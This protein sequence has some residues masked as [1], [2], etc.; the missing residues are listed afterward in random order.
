MTHNLI[1]QQNIIS[2]MLARTDTAKFKYGSIQYTS[3]LHCLVRQIDSVG[4]TFHVTHGFQLCSYTCK[5][6]KQSF[7]VKCVF[8]FFKQLIS[9]P[10]HSFD[11]CLMLDYVRIINFR[12][13]I[14]LIIINSRECLQ[15]DVTGNE[16][17][18]GGFG[19]C[20]ERVHCTL[21]SIG[22]GSDT[23]TLQPV[24][25]H[26]TSQTTTHTSTITTSSHTQHLSKKCS[27]AHNI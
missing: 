18:E 22:H 23:D 21:L 25:T 10:A 5:L 24:L 17:L 9:Y 20:N 11:S 4:L 27:P 7:V 15:L 8:K 3:L 1:F 16:L 13:I 26:I 14:I 12:I 19:G 6:H 2:H